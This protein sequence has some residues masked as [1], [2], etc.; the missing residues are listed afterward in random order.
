MP[1][2]LE[3][4]DLKVH[5]GGVK[6]V[7][8]VSL[9]LEEGKLYGV[10]GPN[11]SGKSTLLAA[12]SRLTE[13]T[14]GNLRIRGTDYHRAAASKASRLGIGRTFQTVR[15]LRGLNVLENVML[16]ADT[17]C[18]GTGI[19]GSWVLP[20]RT[21][22][23][24][25]RARTAAQEAIERMK[26]VGLEKANPTLLSYGTQRRVEIARALA[27]NPS[28]LLL[29]EPTAGMNRQERDEIGT[30]MQDLRDQG[31][32]QILVEHDLQMITDVCEHIWVMNF[33]RIIAEGEPAAVVQLPDVQEAYLGKRGTRVAS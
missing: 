29:D 16:G 1:A 24:E 9:A 21:R 5:Y 27:A 17:R 31:L 23:C 7:D 26:L 8:G 18:F 11:G 3:V 12:L 4:D 10:V 19:L 20:W 22:R 14:G 25:T 32:T 6:A 15:L 2:F 33:G 28:L 13:P 30:I